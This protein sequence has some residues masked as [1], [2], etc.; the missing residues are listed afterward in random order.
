MKPDDNTTV[1]P[2]PAAD[3]IRQ[4]LADLYVVEP[5][6]KQE[7]QEVLQQ[8]A[9]R[10]KHQAY[11]YELST[12]GKSLSEIQA[13]WHEYYSGLTDSDKHEVW[14]EF[15][16]AQN[17]N[18]KSP[19]HGKTVYPVTKL[20]VTNPSHY[21]RP[22]V[23]SR[24]AVTPT[25]AFSGQVDLI[26]SA[27]APKH[28]REYKRGTKSVAEIKQQLLS[29]VR[30]RQKL[31][32]RHHVQSLIFGLGMGSLVM[33]ILLF[34]FFNE[35]FIA[36]FITPSRKVS[37]TPLIIDDTS[38][39]TT[40]PAPKVIIPKI[41]VEIPVVYDVPTIEEGAVETGLE[42]GVVHY[43]STPL[44][45]QQGNAVIF[46]HS[47]NNIFNKGQYKF[48]FVLL[49]RLETGDTFYLTKDSKRYTYR[50]YEKK[51]V[52]PTSVEVLGPAAKPNTATLITC[53]PP[54][55]SLNRLIV[56]GEQISPDPAG[57]VASTAPKTVEKPRI[58]PSNS[59][60]LWDRLTGWL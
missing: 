46:G 39:T 35:R 43:A 2:N 60:T 51:I 20:P 49:S 40:D 55:T 4:K 30:N 27:P 17:H 11:M 41:N 21:K 48:A 52:A 33:L 16:S 32:A 50:V 34:G 12:S 53:D 44:P 5:S 26:Q 3:L 14:R 28:R 9:P 38:A 8:V 23:A 54:G 45:G 15:Y 57:N 22:H 19:S 10:S 29:T 25:E 13:A 6:A 18:H 56:I 58:V 42:R 37:A 7:E 1:D 31:K 24:P 59:P 47:S 36:P